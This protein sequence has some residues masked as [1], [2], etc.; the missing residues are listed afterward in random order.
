M[1]AE[2]WAAG[3]R[4]WGCAAPGVLPRE[5]WGLAWCVGASG[6]G[7]VV[8]GKKVT[9]G[10]DPGTQT[11]PACASSTQE[12]TQERGQRELCGVFT[13]VPTCDGNNLRMQR[14]GSWVT[15]RPVGMWGAA[16]RGDCWG[17]GGKQEWRLGIKA[18]P[19][20]AC[21]GGQV[22]IWEDL[23]CSGGLEPVGGDFW[24]GNF[25]GRGE[26]S[27]CGERMERLLLCRHRG[28]E[29]V[30]LGPVPVPCL[31]WGAPGRDGLQP[32]G[33]FPCG[34]GI[35][36]W[37]AEI[38]RFSHQANPCNSD[39]ERREHKQVSLVMPRAPQ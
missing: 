10:V 32:H 7:L 30:E 38:T 29:F 22:G 17:K 15:P 16:H 20:V 37:G 35:S 1:P 12:R 36:P 18:V 4:R 23:S 33:D 21:L 34:T 28:K 2:G 19:G 11:I 8:L 26:C 5:F 27:G 24:A 39:Q 31:L 13:H 9:S 6:G 25:E 14:G 3:G